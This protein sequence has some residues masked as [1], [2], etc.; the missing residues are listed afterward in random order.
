MTE[1]CHGC[2]CLCVRAAVV[3]VAAVV[4]I[5]RSGS[6]WFGLECVEDVDVMS[7]LSLCILF[8]LMWMKRVR[9]GLNVMKVIISNGGSLGSCIDEERSKVR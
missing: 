3:V 5:A 9:T 7:A 8:S 6:V 1:C 4:V 2:R